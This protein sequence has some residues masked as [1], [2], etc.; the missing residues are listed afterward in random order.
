MLCPR[1]CN[2][3]RDKN[4][5]VCL[6][7]NTLKVARASLHFWEEPCLS[8]DDGSGTI[9]FSNCNLKCV[10]C[11]N[12]DISL[13]HSGK[14]ITID[15][16]SEICIELQ[17]KGAL[18]I[19][20]VTPTHY[21]KQ[22]KEGLI[23]AKEKGLIIPVVYNTSSYENIISLFLTKDELHLKF[24]EKEQLIKDIYSFIFK[25][26]VS[27]KNI[28]KYKN[29]ISWLKNLITYL[30]TSKEE[31]IDIN[32][33]ASKYKIKIDFENYLID[34]IKFAKVP[35]SDER[36]TSRVYVDD[37][38]ITI[39]KNSTVEID[40]A[41]SC[42]KL[43]NG[44]Y[45]LGVHIASVL[46][47]FEYESAIVDEAISRVHTIY[48]KNRYRREK[49][50]YNKIIPIFPYEFSSKVASLLPNEARYARSYYF[51]IDREGNVVNE[52]YF[53][54]IVKSK[55]KTS[56]NEVNEILENGC[57]D[58]KLLEVI[59]N[60]SEVVEV[61]ESKYKPTILY[62][63]IKENINDYSD[64]RVKRE[65]A[66]KIV[67]YATLLTG[68]RVAEY[69]ADKKYPFLYRVHEISQENNDKL[70]MLINNLSNNPDNRKYKKLA[71]LLE[72]VYPKG[73]YAMSGEHKGLRLSHY[74]HCTSEIRRGPDIIAEL[75]LKTCYDK[76]PTDKQLYY[77]E[78]EIKRREIEINS[79]LQPIE[80]FVQEFGRSYQKKKK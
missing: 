16:F 56:Y 72:T 53:N 43:E 21:I 20:L 78:N 44:N 57:K 12:K 74:C 41:L 28:K 26:S 48:L 64:L 3:D 1:N 73:Y 47:Y 33:L 38:L 22:I 80:W 7:S 76:N 31:K 34:S 8:G 46:S 10:F 40:D 61:L 62:E 32:T 45:L 66:E 11:Q 18:N 67:Y 37:Y 2:V 59:S 79:K 70:Q 29:E 35:E 58:E 55:K 9:F 19:N 71:D 69:F 60:L 39:D 23:K 54:T 6:A 15:R 52:K 30:K 4:K 17:N 27:K 25:I 36:D 5:G 42:R 77:L 24:N 49:D 68:N 75:A 13:G 63:K 65:G 51:E 14:E 50:N